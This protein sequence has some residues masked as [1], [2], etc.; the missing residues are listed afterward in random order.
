[1]RCIGSRFLS[2]FQS[3]GTWRL[4]DSSCGR[5]I[6]RV[7]KHSPQIASPFLSYLSWTERDYPD[8]PSLQYK[9]ATLESPGFTHPPHPLIPSL[10]VPNRTSMLSFI[11]PTKHG[12]IPIVISVLG[13]A[14]SVLAVPAASPTSPPVI[15]PTPPPSARALPL[16]ARDGTVTRNSGEDSLSPSKIFCLADYLRFLAIFTLA[17][18]FVV[19]TATT[20]RTYDWTLSTAT[21]GQ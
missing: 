20:T 5:A 10:F 11:S 13:F 16:V 14:S 3:L 4:R 18:T 6:G 19:T 8:W 21:G 1:M 17:S 2:G 7:L 9:R 15:G 12:F